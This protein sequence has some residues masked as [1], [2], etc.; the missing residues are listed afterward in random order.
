[1][2]ASKDRASLCTAKEGYQYYPQKNTCN[3]VLSSSKKKLCQGHGGFNT[4]DECVYHCYDYRKM[5]ERKNV[6]SVT[7][8][9]YLNEA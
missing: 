7:D 1:M 2:P 9:I 8:T 6:D 5:V 4:I 3:P